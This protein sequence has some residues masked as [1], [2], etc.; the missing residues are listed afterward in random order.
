MPAPKGNKFALNNN[1]GCPTLYKEEYCQQIIDYFDIEPNELIDIPHYKN[2][3]VSWVDKKL[4]ASKLP[5]FHE[6]AKSIGVTHKTLLNWCDKHE[7]FLQAYTYAKELQKYFIAENG[8]NNVYNAQFAQFVMKNITDWK[9]KQE[10]DHKSSDGSMSPDL[11]KL[12]TE[13]LEKRLKYVSEIEKQTKKN[14]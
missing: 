2:G 13:E 14:D 5:K 9:D 3:E 11:S 1:G 7:E 10:I 12:P 6:F 4:V 8:L